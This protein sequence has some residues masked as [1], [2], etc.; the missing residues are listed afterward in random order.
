LANCFAQSR[1]L[2]LGAP[3][4]DGHRHYPGNQ[5]STTL[6]LDELSPYRLGQLIALYEHQVYVAS[7]LW[8]INPFDQWGV[9][10]GKKMATKTYGVL[11][12]GESAE[13]LDPSTRQLLQRVLRT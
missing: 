9:E 8:N 4:D 11:T 3:S 1:G 12:R 5:P 6:L 2:M 7:V 10:L 13:A